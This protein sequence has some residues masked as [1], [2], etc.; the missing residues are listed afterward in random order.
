LA[1][2]GVENKNIS[3][4]LE[5]LWQENKHFLSSLEDVM[6]NSIENFFF[7]Q[8]LYLLFYGILV[9]I[10]YIHA[11]KGVPH[12][13]KSCML[14]LP[15]YLSQ[16]EESTGLPLR[17][18][19]F[20]SQDLFSRNLQITY[21]NFMYYEDVDTNVV[22]VKMDGDILVKI[23]FPVSLLAVSGIGGVLNAISNLFGK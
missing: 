6:R 11:L 16:V 5:K 2:I 23:T 10:P 1:Y 13:L 21:K 19:L 22:P 15:G 7:S 3:K 18:F 9:S 4:E 17:Y 12:L 8:E 14:Y 20:E